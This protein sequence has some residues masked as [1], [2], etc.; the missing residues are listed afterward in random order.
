MVSMAGVETRCTPY[1]GRG[2]IDQIGLA[3]FCQTFSFVRQTVH[4]GAQLL[5][6]FR[7]QRVSEIVNLA[8]RRSDTIVMNDVAEGIC[9]CGA[10]SRRRRR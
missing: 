8:G 10:D 6:V 7:H 2:G 4:K 5:E 3:I 9:I 1:V